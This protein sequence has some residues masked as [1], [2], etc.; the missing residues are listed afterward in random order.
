[1]GVSDTPCF[2]QRPGVSHAASRS[3]AAAPGLTTGRILFIQVIWSGA[4]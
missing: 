3:I 2:C 4:E 1:M